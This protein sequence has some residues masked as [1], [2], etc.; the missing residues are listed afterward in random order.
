MQRVILCLLVS[1]P[2]ITTFVSDSQEYKV[3]LFCRNIKNTSSK[4]KE[5]NY[6]SLLVGFKLGPHESKKQFERQE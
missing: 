5:A 4:K 6:S 1:I 3:S 2:L